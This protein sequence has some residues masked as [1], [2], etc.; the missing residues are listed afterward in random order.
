MQ[1]SGDQI[2]SSYSHLGNSLKPYRIKHLAET[3]IP[4]RIFGLESMSERRLSES[5][6]KGKVLDRVEAKFQL[7]P[8]VQ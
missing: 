5:K 2:A 6:K 8:V 4:F 1:C 7:H 3:G